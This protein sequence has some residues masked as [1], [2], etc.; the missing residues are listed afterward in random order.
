[1]HRKRHGTNLAEAFHGLLQ[2]HALLPLR[3][4]NGFLLA[5]PGASTRAGRRLCLR[6]GDACSRLVRRVHWQGER[7]WTEQ[8]CRWRCWRRCASTQTP[9]TARARYVCHTG[10][11]VCRSTTAES[12]RDRRAV[13]DQADATTNSEARACGDPQWLTHWHLPAPR[14]LRLQAVTRRLALFC[15]HLRRQLPNDRVAQD[16]RARPLRLRAGARVAAAGL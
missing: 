13:H 15:A 9:C 3:H 4:L 2:L 1:M 6:H 7:P 16:L 11:V 12:C 5:T 8:R 10:L 14:S